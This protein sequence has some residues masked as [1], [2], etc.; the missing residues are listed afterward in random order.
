LRNIETIAVSR[1]AQNDPPTENIWHRSD[2]A[3]QSETL[4][5]QFAE[6][7]RKLLQNPIAQSLHN[8]PVPTEISSKTALIPAA[9]SLQVAKRLW[10]T[11]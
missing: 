7:H 2:L 1:K 4:S 9:L 11:A 5:L 6:F 10:R 8:L 3:F